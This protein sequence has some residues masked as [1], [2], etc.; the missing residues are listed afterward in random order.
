M[1]DA[2]PTSAL[3]AH[4]AMLYICAA[5]GCPTIVFGNGTCVEHDGDPAVGHRRRDPN[6]GRQERAGEAVERLSRQPLMTRGQGHG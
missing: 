5:S 6:T 1:N 4:A 2:D 3:V